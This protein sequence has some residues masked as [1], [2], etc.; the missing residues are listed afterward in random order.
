[1]LN[2]VLRLSE[3]GWVVVVEGYYGAYECEDADEI[4]DAMEEDEY[5]SVKV[6]VLDSDRHVYLRLSDDE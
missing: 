6:E 5:R 1:M 4:V 3:Q 2:E